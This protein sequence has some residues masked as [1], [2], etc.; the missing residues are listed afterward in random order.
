[1][2]RIGKIAA[3][4]GLEGGV[5]LTHILKK[6]GWLKVGDPI[7]IAVQ[8]D[9]RIPFFVQE[10]VWKNDGECDLRLEEVDSPETAKGLA[11]KEVFA[12]EKLVGDSGSDS[13]LLYIG[14]SMV[15]KQLGAVGIIEDV[16]QA[17]PQWLAQLT[18]NGKE[19]LVPLVDAFIVEV[20]TRNKFIR[21]DLPDG[22]LDV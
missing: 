13:P 22:L 17:G 21:T 18:V 20:N 2:F 6:Q 5:V 12:E 8:R 3:A 14:F 16:Y 1:M 15:D 19:A 9:S 10:V 4:R 11:G 7:F